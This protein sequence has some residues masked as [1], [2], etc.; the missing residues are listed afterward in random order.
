MPQKGLT[1]ENTENT[2][3]VTESSP[4]DVLMSS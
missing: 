3:E 2:E 4:S 1:T